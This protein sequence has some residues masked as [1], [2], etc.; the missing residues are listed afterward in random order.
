VSSDQPVSGS[1]DGVLLATLAYA[2][3]IDRG[4]VTVD[5]RMG[6]YLDALGAFRRALRRRVF[7]EVHRGLAADLVAHLIPVAVQMALEDAGRQRVA[8]H[9]T[10]LA[11]ATVAGAVR[12]VRDRFA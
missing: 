7:T 3:A 12:E 2:A 5:A 11:T 6:G 4:D 10:R 8:G 9:V 1:E